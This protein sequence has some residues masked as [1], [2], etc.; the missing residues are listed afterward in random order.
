MIAYGYSVRRHLAEYRLGERRALFQSIQ[1][2]ASRFLDIMSFA[3]GSFGRGGF[4]ARER[5][6]ACQSNPAFRKGFGENVNMSRFKE[7]SKVLEILAD[8]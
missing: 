8:P 2:A 1:Q 6:P 4:D 7:P 5:N 3:V